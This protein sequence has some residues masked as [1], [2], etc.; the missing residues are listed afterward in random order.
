MFSNKMSGIVFKSGETVEDCSRHVFA[1][2]FIV[3]Y[4]LSALI[5]N[6]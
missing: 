4:N 1:K 3:L 6:N 5:I 2:Y